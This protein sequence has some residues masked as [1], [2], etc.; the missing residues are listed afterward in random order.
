MKRRITAANIRVGDTI[1]GDTVT[2]TA[3]SG[4]MVVVTVYRM[5]G[6]RLTWA[7]R[8]GA[9]VTVNRRDDRNG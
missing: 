2:K 5:S 9:L 6:V 8:P 7:L 4:G 1:D 3:E